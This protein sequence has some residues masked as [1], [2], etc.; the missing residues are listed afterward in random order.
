MVFFSGDNHDFLL[1]NQR[2]ETLWQRS[3][4]PCQLLRSS[5]N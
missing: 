3:V 5:T 4:D 2:T 1:P